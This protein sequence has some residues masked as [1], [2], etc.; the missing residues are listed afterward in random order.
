MD[1]VLNINDKDVLIDVTTIDVSNPSNGFILG[2]D[3][4]PS[5]FPQ[6]GA[7]AA[8]KARKY[9]QVIALSKKIPFVIETQG[10]WDI[11]QNFPPMFACLI[12]F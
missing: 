7:T 9:N 3:L 1:L 10:R 12:H 5:Y 4:D 2:A 8:I 11:H 6:A